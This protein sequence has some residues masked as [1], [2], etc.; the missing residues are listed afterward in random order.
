MAYSFVLLSAGKGVRFGREIPKQYLPF[1][2]KPMIVHILEKIEK[3]DEISEVIVVC[4]NDYRPKILD[5]I[6]VY[7]LNK[8]IIFAEGGSNRQESVFNGL[9]LCSSEDVII[10]EAARPLVTVNDFKKL[11]FN[12]NK[13]VTYSYSIPYTVLR[14]DQTQNI[15]GVLNREEL[16]NV[17]LPQKFDKNLL[18][19]AH[20]KAK[21]E[22]KTFTEDASLLYYYTNEKI[23]CLEGK[24]YNV[25][26]TEYIDLIYGELLLKENFVS[27]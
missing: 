27:E 10:H 21:A 25:K 11:I 3:V 17:Q 1:A 26:M 23:F 20:L 13:N 9:M 2:G 5:Y 12:E 19:D 24:S 16:I 7:R 8:K 4:N 18:L 22:G 6:K 14:K 15:S